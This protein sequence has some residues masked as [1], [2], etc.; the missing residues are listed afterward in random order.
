MAK[1][2]A[3]A[4]LIENVR[5]I[6]DNS[7][8]HSIVLDLEKSKGGDDTGP[9]ALELAVMALADC[10]ITICADVAKNSKIALTKV[11]AI[12]EAEKSPDSPKLTGVNMKVHVQERQENNCWRLCGEEPKQ[13]AQWSTSS[14]S[15]YR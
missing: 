15:R 9:T 5:T 10:A 12:A 6:A 2:K 4:K 14:R 13:T 7:R 3:T 11:E 1:I 8:T